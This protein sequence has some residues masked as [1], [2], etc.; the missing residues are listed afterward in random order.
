MR[1]QQRQ[2][3]GLLAAIVGA[4]SGGDGD[5]GNDAARREAAVEVARAVCHGIMACSSGMPAVNLV[6]FN[7]SDDSVE[8]GSWERPAEFVDE[9]ACVAYTQTTPCFDD[10]VTYVEAV[11]TYDD[12]E[13]PACLDFYAGADCSLIDNF[14][15]YVGTM[16][17]F[18]ACDGA[19]VP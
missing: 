14:G 15:S 1:P 9:D 13:L 10:L 19:F 16:P 8:P 7:W 12:A 4:C 2:L 17:L 18:S 6:C 5:G 11:T 3:V